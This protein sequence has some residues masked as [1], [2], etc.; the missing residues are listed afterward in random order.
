MNRSDFRAALQSPNVRALLVAIRLGE[1]T[2]DANGYRRLVGGG[3]FESFADHPRR[4]IWIPAY[5]VYS[6]AA[7][8]YQFLTKTWDALASAYG[9]PDFSPDSQDE[10]AVALIAER[11]AL[12]D[13]LAGR[14]D[15]AIRKIAP[16]WASLPGAGYGQRE[17]K[18]ERVRTAYLAAGGQLPGREEVAVTTDEGAP[19]PVESAMGGSSGETAAASGSV[20]TSLK[21]KIMA[22]PAII[23]AAIP[24]LI[25]AVPELTKIFSDR[26]ADS[27]D[28]YTRAAAK[29][30]EIAV[31]ATA[32]TNLQE[33]T[34]K[35]VSDPSAASAFRG[36]VREGWYE[37]TESGGGGIAG[38][39]AAN[40]EAAAAPLYRQ[41]AFAVS[42]MLLPL[43]YAVALL[44]L[45]GAA[46]EGFSGELKAAI[47]M[48][49]ISG[50][51]GAITGFWL[52]SSFTTSR[53]R[54]LGATG[55]DA[56]RG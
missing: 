10:A 13:I 56:Q 20:Y 21:G 1:G 14:F 32:S 29:V 53:S 22:L 36:A 16:I 2:S 31:A 17:E 4:R 23:A 44:V 6:S 49:I 39:R 28:Q 52:G 33:A 3:E 24:S 54:G 12:P 19:E 48:A 38:A 55:S 41:P 9:F 45:T 47:A 26:S 42:V 35:I 40:I 25:A 27:R 18:L 8:A 37:L 46:A 30:A 50:V 43:V 15:D 11:G 5:R 51:L 7:G 34:E